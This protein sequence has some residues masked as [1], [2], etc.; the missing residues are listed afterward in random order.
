MWRRLWPLIVGALGVLLV[1]WSAVGQQGTPR[2]ERLA[3][4]LV[5]LWPEYDRPDMLV[6]Y[7]I[8]LP[9][10]TLLPA[11]VAVRIPARVGDPFA[12]A[13]R[14]SPDSPPINAAYTTE[15]EGEWQWVYITANALDVQLEYYDALERDGDTRRYTFIWPGG[16]AVDRFVVSVQQPATAT[17]LT[18]DPPEDTREPGLEGLMHFVKEF[19]ALGPQDQVQLTVEYV[20]PDDVLSVSKIQPPQPQATS[21]AAEAAAKVETQDSMFDFSGSWFTRWFPWFLG[22]AGL[23]MLAIAG[24]LFWRSPSSN[25]LLSQPERRRGRGLHFRA[26]PP[27]DEESDEGDVRYCPQCGARARPGDRFCRMCGTPLR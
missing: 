14:V 19:G 8:R 16:V 26:K 3:Q 27:A 5:E 23:I 7:F 13:V 15:V 20:K 17:M 24:W 4:V 18:L 11:E 2:V 25:V 10:D 9:S 1:G 12:V 21:A 22:V 6:L